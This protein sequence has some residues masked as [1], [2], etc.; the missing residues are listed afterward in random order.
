M[1]R[2]IGGPVPEV[3]F[4]HM[5][6]L[7]L[8][9]CKVRALR[10]GM[11]GQAGFEVNGPWEEKQ[12]LHDLLHEAAGEDLGLVDVGWWAYVTSCIES[13]WLCVELPGFYAGEGGRAYRESDADYLSSLGGSFDS[14][15]LR[16]Y[17][18]TPFE[19]G[20][21][22]FVDLEH[23]SISRAALTRMSQEPV[24]RRKVTLELDPEDIAG[25]F[26]GMQHS[27]EELPTQYLR[28]QDSAYSESQFEAVQVDGATV[29]V[30]TTMAYVAPH[31]KV[32]AIGVVDEEYAE[33]GTEVTV[34][35]GDSPKF[36]RSN[37]EPHRQVSLRATVAPSP[38]TKYAR[39]KYRK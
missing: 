35:W 16:D 10:H 27:G 11:A 19:L 33:A 13:G 12:K 15:E 14:P 17:L 39:E 29:G 32:L 6:D 24:K 36:P 9:G 1:E 8:G 38:Y 22:R 18:F 25:V 21:G 2:V 5:T 37:V 28:L 26:A 34:L 23:D 3:K 4:F 30:V 7:D 31:R 20:Y